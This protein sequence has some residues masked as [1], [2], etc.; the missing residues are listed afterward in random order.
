[1]SDYPDRK[2]EVDPTNLPFNEQIV[3]RSEKRRAKDV[4]SQIHHG[5][6]PLGD[7][8]VSRALLASGAW[9]RV[10]QAIYPAFVSAEVDVFRKVAHR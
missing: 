3:V 5:V 7:G 8:P 2:T 9:D 6:V 10:E 4:A 1:V